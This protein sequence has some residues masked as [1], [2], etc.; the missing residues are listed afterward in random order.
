MASRAP[1]GDGTALVPV[2]F[3]RPG[4]RTIAGLLAGAAVGVAL[5]RLG[6]DAGPAGAGGGARA[7]ERLVRGAL[8]PERSPAY[9]LTVA[10]DAAVTAAYAVAAM[11]LA[12]V[13]GLV[14]AVI[15][16][17]VL[18]DRAWLRAGCRVVLALT[19]SAHELVWA[20]LFVAAMGLSPMAGVLAIAVPYAGVIGRVLGDRL[21]DVDPAPVR[22]LTAAGASPLSRLFYGV[23][24]QVAPDALGYLAYRLECA[25]RSAAVLSFVGLGGLGFRIELALRDLDYARAWTPIYATLLLVVLVDWLGARTRR[26]FAR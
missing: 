10:G 26:R 13:V 1:I 19:R 11:S 12:T 6:A 18:L 7:L 3:R 8:A 22:A 17:G 21:R 4:G 23:V 2:P 20:L 9:L 25:L 16:S 15:A 14:A 24:P 5:L